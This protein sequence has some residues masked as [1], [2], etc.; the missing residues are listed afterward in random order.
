MARLHSL[1]SFRLCRSNDNPIPPARSARGSQSGLRMYQFAVERCGCAGRHGR[2]PCRA[3]IRGHLVGQKPLRKPHEVWSGVGNERRTKSDHRL[4]SLAFGVLSTRCSSTLRLR[5][6]SSGPIV[7]GVVPLPNNP[8]RAGARV[9]SN[10]TRNR[11]R[12][13]RLLFRCR[14]LRR[15]DIR[16]RSILGI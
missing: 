13:D 11:N 9:R 1:T 6:G 3:G 12:P 14:S 15:G 10:R 4:S 7:G 2:K 8:R 5:A 16:E